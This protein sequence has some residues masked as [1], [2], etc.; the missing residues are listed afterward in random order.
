MAIP[1]KR[2]DRAVVGFLSREEIEAIL[3][4]LDTATW[5]GQR[6]A[7]L[8]TMLYNTGARVSEIITIKCSDVVEPCC[9]AVLLHGKGRKERV[10]PLWKRTSALLRHWMEQSG[11]TAQQPL[12][13]NRFGQPMTRSGVASRLKVAVNRACSRCPSLRNKVISPHVIRHYLPFLIMSSNL[14][15]SAQMFGNHRSC[16]ADLHTITRHSFPG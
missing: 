2:F 1:M 15:D 14:M 5:S 11:A 10:V 8:L 16:H 3:S 6:D 13:P 12:F 4:A 9:S 7:V